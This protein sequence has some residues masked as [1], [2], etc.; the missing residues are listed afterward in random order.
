MRYLTFLPV[1]LLILYL[2]ISIAQTTF[3]DEILIDGQASGAESVYSIDL[4]CDGDNDVLA[5]LGSCL[6]WYENTDG[7]GTFGPQHVIYTDDEST[8]SVFSIDLDGDGDN[9][10]LAV[11]YWYD[12][13]TWYENLDGLGMFGPQ[14]IISTDIHQAKS[15][16]STD[17]DGDGDNDVLSADDKIAWYENTNGL[18]TF[19]P[20]QI[21]TNRTNSATSVYSTDLDGDGDNDVLSASTGDDKIAWYENTDGQGTFGLQQI[22]TTNANGAQ[23]VYSTDLD[24]DGDNDVLSASCY[25]DKIAWYENLDGLG[26][27]GTQRVIT[28]S[29]DVARSVYSIDLDGDG[30][31]DI[32]SASDFDDKIAW[33]ENTDGF[34]T[35]GPQQIISANANGATSV[36]SADLDGDTCFDVLSTSYDDS[37]IAWYLNE[38]VT[39][40]MLINLTYLSGS[41][42]PAAGGDLH[43]T[44]FG[45]NAAPGSLTHD[46]W[47]DVAY[48][49]GLPTTVLL[50]AF[51]NYLSGWTFNRP[52]MIFPVPETY[53]AGEYTFTAKVGY[54]PEI[55]WMEDGFPFTKT[56]NLYDSDFVPF[57]VACAPNPFVEIPCNQPV[58]GSCQ[59]LVLEITPNP[60]NPTT[61]TSF[62][63]PVAS[64]VTLSVY[65]VTGRDVGA[66]FNPAQM[67]AGHHSF[68][69]DGTS[70]PSG[71]YLY[72]LTAADFTATGKMVLLK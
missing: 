41:P 7:Q 6:A 3:S 27:F 28:T 43:Y 14:Q 5:A 72:R 37:K 11:S 24:G 57:A 20:Q 60:F 51:Q 55:I 39:S 29:A 67:Q 15:V 46:V 47:L 71:I 1:V 44:I 50:Q 16:Y 17:L 56:G 64:T 36:Y 63:L 30:D 59:L 9:D 31:N 53:A 52:D 70:L 40:R 42:I 61:T 38:G 58:V 45:E 68:T 19:G 10:V 25:D 12:K 8:I 65:D 49:G 18:G 26:E 13:I 48:Q 62:D 54:Y 32:L 4:D 21:I 22:I 66:G 23:S 34:G 33:Y 2:Q 35:F 69:F